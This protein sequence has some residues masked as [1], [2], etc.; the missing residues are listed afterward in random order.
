MRVYELAKQLG[1][2]N[3]TLIPE[4]K[5]LGISVAS[6]SSALD[7][8]AVQKALDQL[9]PKAGVGQKGLMGADADQKKGSS[10]KVGHSSRESRSTG[11]EEDPK[12]GFGARASSAAV[13]E[14]PKVDKKRIL[15]KR[16][17]TD[18]EIELETVAAAPIVSP[19]PSPRLMEAGA[20]IS[21]LGSMPTEEAS[22]VPLF[23]LPT[24]HH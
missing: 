18:E 15:I 8:A 7:E 10:G 4:L 21:P 17:K 14:A 12:G 24:R 13:E 3:R 20:A 16:K 2:D 5:R 11:R 9:M 1:M 6:H 22:P 23:M 19:E